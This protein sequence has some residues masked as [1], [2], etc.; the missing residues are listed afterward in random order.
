MHAS[1]KGPSPVQHFSKHMARAPGMRENQTKESSVAV[2]Q[3]Y[4]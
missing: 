2:L 4:N 3:G 1:K